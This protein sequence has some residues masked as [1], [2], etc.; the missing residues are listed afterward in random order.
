[1]RTREERASELR[2][3][4]TAAGIE[5]SD[6]GSGL[7]SVPGAMASI[8]VSLNHGDD[9][10]VRRKHGS[11]WRTLGSWK[12]AATAVRAVSFYTDKPIAGWHPRRF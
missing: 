7:F 6:I 5:V 8:L 12:R 11:R 1:M 10:H 2:A 4:A 3:A 9:F